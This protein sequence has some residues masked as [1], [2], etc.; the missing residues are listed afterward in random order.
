MSS[1]PIAFL[2]KSCFPCHITAG[3]LQS[4]PSAGMLQ[5]T[6]AVLISMKKPAASGKGISEDGFARLFWEIQTSV[7]PETSSL[8]SKRPA[9][10]QP[11][12][13]LCHQSD[14][15]EHAPRRLPYSLHLSTCRAKHRC[16]R[17][18]FQEGSCL[19][20]R[21]RF[22]CHI[23]LHHGIAD[24]E[25]TCGRSER[26]RSTLREKAK[27]WPGS[28]PFGKKWMRAF[29]IGAKTRKGGSGITALKSRLREAVY[30]EGT[31]TSTFSS[32]VMS[33]CDRPACRP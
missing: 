33:S 4:I 15:P 20:T 19:K 11:G 17:P 5:R 12:N 14:L 2:R 1:F 30:A 9:R 16:Q 18:P 3:N 7:D 29:Q 31:G 13:I 26:C 25:R 8:F 27:P 32:N 28:P 23:F 10:L 6:C 24:G 22:F 21:R